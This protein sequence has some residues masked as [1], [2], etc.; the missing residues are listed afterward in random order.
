M[1][2]WSKLTHTTKQT[3][4]KLPDWCLAKEGAIKLTGSW[5]LDGTVLD[6]NG[7]PSGDESDGHTF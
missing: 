6:Y 3:M 5:E 4:V 7:V 2:N 1:E